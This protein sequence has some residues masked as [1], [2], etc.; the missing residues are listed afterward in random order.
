M[1]IKGDVE[2]AAQRRCGRY[3]PCSLRLCRC[4][5]HRG[6]SPIPRSWHHLYGPALSRIGQFCSL[7]AHTLF[8]GVSD[9]GANRSLKTA[10][11]SVR[12][13]AKE[14]SPPYTDL[15]G[16]PPRITMVNFTCR[17]KD[18]PPPSGLP[19][20]LE[21]ISAPQAHARARPCGPETGQSRRRRGLWEQP[22][23]NRRATGCTS[24]SSRSAS[25]AAG[26]ILPSR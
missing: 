20:F 15:K 19:L 17:E 3:G 1:S 24:P 8:S 13:C 21:K 14:H 9:L 5:F 25:C 22:K 23:G 4:A 16:K 2:R 26:T 10:K 12:S 11:L 7:A 6:L 18:R